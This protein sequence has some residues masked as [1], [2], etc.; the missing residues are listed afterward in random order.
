[1][2]D[3]SI[4]NLFSLYRFS[5]GRRIFAH[6]VV[7]EH[8]VHMNLGKLIAHIDSA[9]EFDR[10]LNAQEA[11]WKRRDSAPKTHPR[12]IDYQID[13]IHGAISSS[14]LQATVIFEPDS[15]IRTQA[16]DLHR[17]LYPQGVATLTR[18]RHVDQL[19]ENSRVIQELFAPAWNTVLQ[20]LGLG[21]YLQRLSALNADFETLL[22]IAHE[23]RPK[24]TFDDI[25]SARLRG[26]DMMCTTIAHIIATFPGVSPQHIEA[27]QTLF[28]PIRQQNERIG[29]YLTRRS[30]VPEV[31]PDTG[32][33]SPAPNEEQSLTNS[34]P[35]DSNPSQL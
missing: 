19:L 32:Q 35:P 34:P 26:Q 12:E 29:T 5:T 18:L 11:I 16:Q 14:L 31:D 13:R 23:D 10:L 2:A 9:L 1:M 4:Y 8:A 7:R 33:E 25:R 6:K 28:A 24:Q 15:P 3:A 30:T 17:V 22:Q 20:E 27:R 21:M